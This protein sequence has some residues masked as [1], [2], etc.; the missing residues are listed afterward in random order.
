MDTTQLHKSWPTATNPFPAAGHLVSPL[1][2]GLAEP[3][4]NAVLS[5]ATHQVFRAKTVVTEE[6][7]PAEHFYLLVSGRARFFFLTREG[8]KVI[9]HC[10]VPGEGLGGLALVSEPMC[11]MVSSETVTQTSMLVWERAT[12]RSLLVHVPQL[13]DNALSMMAKYLVLYRIEHAGLI[14][15]S[16][17]ERLATV[18][19]D[20]ARCT[21]HA[22]AKGVE[23]NVTNEEL[24]SAANITS[25]TA[26]RLLND[27]QRKKLI[28]KKRGRI[29]VFSPAKF[30]SQ[31]A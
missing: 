4:L 14:C 13:L 17:R 18:V 31:A 29:L 9:L 2:A 22:T 5:A 12:L 21:G 19:S 30:V 20:L 3:E 23:L 28:S 6:G 8:R 25:F 7:D 16:A 1:L 15:E 27:W 24:A 11:Y 26:S 10:L